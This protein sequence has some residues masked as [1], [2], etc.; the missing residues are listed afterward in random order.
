MDLTVSAALALIGLGAIVA[1]AV[2]ISLPPGERLAAGLALV[3]GAGAGL[4]ALA[5]GFGG[6]DGSAPEGDYERVFLVASAVG[7]AAVV[8]SA[9]VLRR[10]ARP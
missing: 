7:F 10:R 5:V 2:G 3:I 4:V 8:A 6:L 9:A 1:G